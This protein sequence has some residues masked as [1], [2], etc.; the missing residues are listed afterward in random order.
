MRM[1]DIYHGPSRDRAGPYTLPQIIEKSTGFI[2][3]GALSN[4]IVDWHLDAAPRG[5]FAGFRVFRIKDALQVDERVS[6]C[7]AVPASAAQ[8][9]YL[10][11]RGVFSS[12]R[13]DW[14]WHDGTVLS[15][16][17]NTA[18]ISSDDG[19]NV[20]VPIRYVNSKE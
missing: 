3:A 14:K 17:E 5:V 12:A 18:T 4:L 16:D 15:F 11:P 1:F 7:E 6:W 13:Y 8:V 10:P 20:T 9:G 19:R 2:D